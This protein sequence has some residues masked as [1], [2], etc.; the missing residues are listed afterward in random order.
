MKQN[1]SLI[2]KRN[3][4]T[5]SWGSLLLAIVCFAPWANAQSIQVDT[6]LTPR[7]FREG[8]EGVIQLHVKNTGP[9]ALENIRITHRLPDA[10]TLIGSASSQGRCL[11]EGNVVTCRLGDLA[12]GASATLSVTGKV[13]IAVPLEKEAIEVKTQTAVSQGLEPL[14]ALDQVIVI[15]APRDFG[16]APDN[17]YPTLLASNGARHR[18]GPLFLGNQIDSELDGQPNATATG[19]DINPM[20][21]D[22]DGIRLVDPLI[23]GDPVR[24]RVR[25]S[26]AGMLSGWIDY[27]QNG[28]WEAAE[29]IL[30]CVPVVAGDQQFT[31]IVPLGATPGWTYA[32]FRLGSNCVNSVTGYVSSGEVEDYR[33][34]VRPHDMGNDLRI[35][36]RQ[37]KPQL[38]WD[39]PEGVVESASELAGDFRKLR[40]LT[41]PAPL[42]S[43]ESMRFFRLGMPSVGLDFVHLVRESDLIFEGTV[44]EIKYRQSKVTSP[45]HVSL[46]HTFVKFEVHHVLKGNVAKDTIWLRFLG[47]QADDGRVLQTSN[48]TLFDIGERSL[49]FVRRNG[50]SACPLVGASEGRFRIHDGR[51]Y[52][53]SGR[54]LL[55]TSEGQVDFGPSEDL[56]E[57]RKNQI[58]S[59]SMELRQ[60]VERDPNESGPSPKSL[61]EAASMQAEEFR[62]FVKRLMGHI[63]SLEANA[64][65]AAVGSL[66]PDAPFSMKQPKPMAPRG[67]ASRANNP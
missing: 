53:E 7:V 41:S 19:D 10:L 24:L 17:P 14:T 57:V 15:L 40:N 13:S 26:G 56:D 12:A 66:D 30:N 36:N 3:R 60:V 65:T 58:G 38:E 9:S 43:N 54:P 34:R 39:H 8:G 64:K 16:D 29:Q 11:E 61:L 47:G 48:T 21:D 63:P 4:R 1:S 23:A 67:A 6:Q 52:N 62:D 45:D 22:E 55:W 18:V 42:D 32:R 5:C 49:L 35:A 44:T 20:P 2:W 28:V 27:N 46:P 33:F 50:Q 31:T 37:G 51:V 59:Q 25:S